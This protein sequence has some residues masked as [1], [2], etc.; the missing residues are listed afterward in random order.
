M[1][2]MDQQVQSFLQDFKVKL[3]IWGIIFRD[4][5]DKNVQT[6]LDLDISP[7]LREKVV[8]ELLAIDYCE[9]PLQEMLYG[10]ADMWVFGKIV[11]G[12]EI[13][14]KINLGFAGREVICISFHVAKHSLKYPLKK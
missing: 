13:Y 4:D 14:I 8:R 6:L 2:T 12:Q 9:G 11:K 1:S 10:G 3:G 7:L 5:R